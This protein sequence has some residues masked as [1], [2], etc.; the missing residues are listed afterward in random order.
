MKTSIGN[1]KSLVTIMAA[2]L[3][4]VAGPSAALAASDSV[5]TTI[6]VS[7]S[8]ALVLPGEIQQFS[9]IGL[10]QYGSPLATQPPF[11][12]T[13]SGG[14]TIANS[15]LFT[16][17]GET[18]GPYS[19]TASAAGLS[20]STNFNIVSTRTVTF[21]SPISI[22]LSGQNG[23]LVA[24]IDG[25]GHQDIVVRT[26]AGGIVFLFGNGDN[27]FTRVDYPYVISG[28]NL[29]SVGMVAGDLNGDGSL[30]IVCNTSTG[31]AVIM[32]AGNRNFARPLLYPVLSNCEAVALG[33]FRENGKLDIACVSTGS[34]YGAATNT[35]TVLL[36]YG[37]GNFGAP[38]NYSIPG[39]YYGYVMG[40]VALDVNSDGHLDLVCSEEDELD[41]AKSSVFLGAGDGT[42]TLSPK[43]PITVAGASLLAT[44]LNNDGILD[45]VA[46]DHWAGQPRWGICDGKGGFSSMTASGNGWAGPIVAADF[47]GCGYKD[48]AQA[49]SSSQN[50]VIFASNG[51]GTFAPWVGYS[52]IA[53]NPAVGDF[54]EDGQ[55]DLVLYSDP[56]QVVIYPNTTNP[57]PT[58]TY[59]SPNIAPVG[60]ALT[61]TIH[62]HGLLSR[63]VAN[64][65][66]TPLPTTFNYLDGTLTASVPAGLLTAPGSAT[67]TVTT[68]S[69]GGGTSNSL[70]ISFASSAPTPTLSPG[71]G[72]YANSVTVTLSD[73]L[74]DPLLK[75]YY[76]TDGSKPTVSSTL[77]SAPFT[78]DSSATV[79]AIAVTS[80]YSNS[81]VGSATYTLL[82]PAPTPT[83][84]PTP[85]SF[86]NTASVTISDTDS[87]ATIYYT[88]D[89]STPTTGSTPYTGPV[90][91]SA[92]STIKAIAVDTASYSNSAVAS[93]TYTLLPPAP[94]PTFSPTPGSFANTAHVTISD[95]DSSAT[96]YY[97]TDGSTPTTSSTPYTGP[98]ALSATSTIKAIAVD[99]ASYSN[100]A[101]ASATYTLLPP[102][103]T[104]TFSRTAGS[105]GNSTNVTISDTDTSATIYYTTDGSTP[106]TSSTPYTG[107]VALTATTTIKAIAVDTASYSNSAVA[108]AVYTL[109]SPAATPSFSPTPGPFA[110]SVSVAIADSTPGATIYYTTDGMTPTTE[111]AQY[112]LPLTVTQATPIN[113]IAV[114]PGYSTS[115]VGSAA[116]S[117]LPPAATPVIMPASGSYPGTR[118][119]TITDGTAGVTIYYTLD[120]STPTT[121]SAVYSAPLT[122]TSTTTIKAI[123]ASGD[124]STSGVA[125]GTITIVSAS[126]F[127]Y[128]AGLNF[129]SSPYDYPGV[130]LDTLFGYTGVKLAVFDP[131]SY[132]W[133]V[134]PTA[135]ADALRLGGGYWAR[136]P[137][138]VTLTSIGTPAPSGSPFA[139]T[140]A[141]GWNMIG[142][143][144]TTAAP[145]SSITFGADG[146]SYAGAVLSGLV[147]PA[148]WAYDSSSNGY[149]SATSLEPL[150]GYW[151][152]AY[153][154]TSM[155]VPHP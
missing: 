7:P 54:N 45:L 68:A 77:Y 132:A 63:S 46:S 120:G 74:K 110:N 131:S 30:D 36:N 50:V 28:F 90:A 138:A 23:V 140:L 125:S 82:P 151:I 114:A 42:F 71:S 6:S 100:S 116:Y 31:V 134:T 141:A 105:F 61:L 2:A 39:G 103:P 32:N 109:A 8:M 124:S 62:G 78:L 20:G 155:S 139:I 11:G 133:A 69:P 121:A 108:S 13:V 29:N 21:G 3:L 106:T 101:V 129:F 104:P 126:G 58:I 70:T 135:P 112:T 4:L 130:A 113:A 73:M 75:F 19:A 38:V 37:E 150:K 57:A 149:I 80:G 34:G 33:D 64:W 92:T 60:T 86:A 67:V 22:P 102:A 145:L 136:F 41:T 49:Y 48:L 10:D 88:T 59:L 18:G 143:P 55:P 66:G 24:D 94:T 115:A 85:G 147:G 27:T 142:D 123:A 89:G 81:A 146:M 51:D 91:L 118:S 53:S 154:A 65:N 44:D 144:F 84:S 56:T 98:V 12:W 122:I 87:S 5:L 72:T 16:A 79:N 1:R 35:L 76:T 152:F 52:L 40:V 148:L 111:S 137:H 97:S 95:A 14:G 119:V 128:S 96:I 93:A 9:A 26:Q 25:D 99:P 153:S 43:S 117:I 17:G 127:S 15:G 107:P 47:D 83:F